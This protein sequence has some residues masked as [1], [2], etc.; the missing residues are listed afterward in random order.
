MS[1]CVQHFK[2]LVNSNWSSSLE[3]PNS[4]KNRR[5]FVPC[6]LEIWR[7]TLKSNKVPPLFYFR[8]CLLFH[9][10]QWNKAGV[11]AQKPL[12]GVKIGYFMANVTLKFDG[13]PWKTIGHH[14]YAISSLVHHFVA[15]NEFKL[16]LQSGN[17]QF[18]WKSSF[19]CHVIPWNLTIGLEER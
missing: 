10:H 11:T 12:I 18:G 5:F 1:N 14:F 15:I 19:I 8:P 13:W 7:I 17:M 4:C 2:S 16:D 6:D 9:S 3:T